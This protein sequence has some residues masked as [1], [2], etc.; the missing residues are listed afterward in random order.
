M[1]KKVSYEKSRLKELLWLM[2]QKHQPTCPLC[3]KEFLKAE[4]LPSH[5]VDQLTEHHVD[6]NHYNNKTANRVLVHRTCHKRHHTKNNI[7]FAQMMRQF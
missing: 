7:I 4:E 3:S 1:S 5:G 2:I 6:G